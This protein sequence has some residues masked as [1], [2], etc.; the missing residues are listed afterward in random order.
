MLPLKFSLIFKVHASVLR[1]SSMIQ[2]EAYQR[3][4]L[5][6]LFSFPYFECGDAILMASSLLVFGYTSYHLFCV[7]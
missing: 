2:S 1:I 6:V 4:G 5:S 3:Q 7:L